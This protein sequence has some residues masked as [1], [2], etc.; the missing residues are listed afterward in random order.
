MK[1]I[2]YG[3]ISTHSQDVERQIEELKT[4]SQVKNFEV[5]QIYTETISG[6][7]NRKQRKE[8]SKLLEY[9]SL[10]DDIKG[11]LV[12]ELSR[13]GRNTL[14]VLD[15][16]NQLQL[17]GIWVYSKKENLYTLN[18]DG[19]EN[20]TTKL[21]L[22]ILSGVSTMERD[23]ILSRS[24]SGVRN[25]INNGN[26]L[27]GK[28][29]PYGYGRENKKLV[30]DEEESEV[31]KMIFSWY[32]EGMGTKK[33][34]NHL[35]K[36]KILTRYNKSLTK[37]IIINDI[38]KNSEDFVWRDGTVYSILTNPVYIGKKVGKGQIEGLKIVSPPIIT[39]T[40]FNNVQY[41]LKHTIKKSSTKFYYLFDNILKCGICNKSYYP[42]K[43]LNNK[44]NRYVCLSKRYGEV[45]NNYGISITKMNDGVW[46]VIRN[47]Q[48][49]L[50]N[51]ISLNSNKEEIEN[52]ILNIEETQ[53]Q[54]IQK[55]DTIERKELR[56]VE[57]FMEEKIDRDIYNKQ[58]LTLSNEKE[59]VIN[60]LNENVQDLEFKKIH[61]KKS[62]DVGH[63]I[64]GIKDDR[65]LLKKSINNVISKIYVYPIYEHNLEY[66][67]GKDFKTNKQDK[68]VF[69][70]VF[71]YSNDKIPLIFVISQ[72][73]DYIISP[74]S[75][76]FDKETNSLI[77]GRKPKDYRGEEEE[78][79]FTYRTLF[80]LSSMDL[81]NKKKTN[82][83]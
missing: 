36:L 23:T 75:T 45:C 26:W 13:L 80:H 59:N 4:F 38:K 35:N 70:E 46:S 74:S 21:T 1:V 28:Y 37:S 31:I 22:T 25:T 47:N 53:T 10:H 24:I 62:N 17:R 56:L 27:G 76:D 9:V 32:L 16:I 54:L 42:H 63:Q 60:S 64:R 29:L 7:K 81:I 71:T 20:P 82:V 12:W 66:F 34:S 65:R 61:L 78:P 72:R 43:R 44:D 73:T 83:S 69:I 55:K 50:Y 19:T 67:T 77:I 39:E 11:V 58:Y 14:D 6:I 79:E 52:E 57:L 33:I 40:E 3:R 48:R 5:V 30:I 41:K 8:I 51:I 2:I 68:F 15:I 49:E 18:E